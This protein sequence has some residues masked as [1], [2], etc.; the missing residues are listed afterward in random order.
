ME[1]DG[2]EAHAA[3]IFRAKVKMDAACAACIRTQHN[4]VVTTQKVIEQSPL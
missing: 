4:A 3:S 1:T 2:W